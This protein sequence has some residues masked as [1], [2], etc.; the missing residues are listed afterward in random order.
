MGRSSWTDHREGVALQA[1]QIHLTHTQQA[2]VGG[3]VRRV[4]R[5]ATLRL[6]R[7]M[8]EHERALLVGMAFVTSGIAARK[9][10]YLAQ[11]RGPVDVV[12]VITLNQSLVDPMVIGFGEV[13]FLRHVTAVTELRFSFHK[14]MLL[15]LGIMRR[16]AIKTRDVIAGVD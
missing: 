2:R 5:T 12:A 1:K 9:S 15:F 13:C 16:M 6:D 4:T 14:Q 8:F 11:G 7:N 3:A 10:L